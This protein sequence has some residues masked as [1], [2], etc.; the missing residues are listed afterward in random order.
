MSWLSKLV[1]GKTL[2]VAALVGA[3]YFGKEYFFGDTSTNIG[4]GDPSTFRYTGDNFAADTLNRFKITP[5]TQTSF[6]Q[7]TLGQAITKTGS[8]L[9]IGQSGG[10]ETVADAVQQLSA[11][12]RFDR[13]VTPGKISATGIRTDTTFQPGQ[14]GRI[15][16]GNGTQVSSALQ[17]DAMRQ[18]LAK[19]VRMMGL[20]AASALPAASPVSTAGLTQTTSAKRRQYRGLTSA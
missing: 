17:T 9:G 8:F 7:S 2:K 3:G 12:Q 10:A 18:Y 20:P 15:P 5:F 6:G 19:Q 16:I 14:I 4:F 13:Q 1:G 11:L